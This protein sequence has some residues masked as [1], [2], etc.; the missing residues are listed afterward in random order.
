MSEVTTE[1]AQ[2]TT[3]AVEGKA[4]APAAT[5][6]QSATETALTAATVETKPAQTTEPAK[7]DPAAKQTPVVPEK[8]ELKLP[9][10]SKLDASSIEKTA[11][12]AK[13]NGL[14]NEQAQS[15]I[16]REHEA[17]QGFA[18][19]QM[20]EFEKTKGSW[21]AELS[22]DK[23][24]GGEALNQNVEMAKRVVTR[25]GTDGFKKA[26]N[27]SGYGDHPE[28]VRVFARIGKAMSEDQL[29]IPGTQTGGKKAIHDMFYGGTSNE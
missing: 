20:E 28:L 3:T 9:K 10:D 4:T 17:V 21:R 14:S 18:K 24:I 8:Y 22:A 19:V 15:L 16:D 26:L 2:A 1:T 23:E 5:A 27:E 13:A 11:A 29:I 7:T 6:T 12:F 25:F